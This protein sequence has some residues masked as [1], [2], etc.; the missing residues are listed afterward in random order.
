MRYHIHRYWRTYLFSSIMI[1]PQMITC[2]AGR[3]QFYFIRNYNKQ[4]QRKVYSLE[5]FYFIYFLFPISRFCYF[6]YIKLIISQ[7]EPV[8]LVN[9]WRLGV[10]YVYRALYKKKITKTN[11]ITKRSNK[12]LLYSLTPNYLMS[13][14]GCRQSYIWYFHLCTYIYSFICTCS[15]LSINNF[16][17]IVNVFVCRTYFFAKSFRYGKF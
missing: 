6:M 2:R 10:I 11:L 14:N 9:C 15:L 5:I 1:L 7:F 3:L 12:H 13:P 8:Q 16:T 4:N 17:S